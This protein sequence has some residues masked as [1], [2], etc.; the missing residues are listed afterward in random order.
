MQLIIGGKGT[1]KTKKLILMS[2]ETGAPI[3]CEDDAEK[4]AIARKSLDHFGRGCTVCTIEEA[5]EFDTVLVRDA[6]A[7]LSK[8]LGATVAGMSITND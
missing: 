6:G 5:K 4:E 8:L 3:V 1:G 2:L 7:L